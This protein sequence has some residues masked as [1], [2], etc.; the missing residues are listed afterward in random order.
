MSLTEVKNSLIEGGNKLSDLLETLKK[1]QTYFKQKEPV[2]LLYGPEL[3]EL[4]TLF[5]DLTKS[6]AL[7]EEEIEN[8]KSLERRIVEETIKALQQ[9]EEEEDPT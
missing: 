7:I 8:R 3:G 5:S 6:I 9:Q 2:I 4:R 1:H